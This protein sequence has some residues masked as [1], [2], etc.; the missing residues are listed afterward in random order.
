MI[1]LRIFS[2][3]IDNTVRSTG[4]ATNFDLGGG[5]RDQ[6]GKFLWHYFGYV[7]TITPL[8]WRHTHFFKLD[9][10]IISLKIQNLAKSRNFRLPVL[11]VMGHWG[12]EPQVLGDFWKFV[13]ETMHFRYNSAQIHPKK[14]WNNISPLGHALGQ[15]WVTN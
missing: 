15:K 6:N 13:T 12:R 10:F 8:K 3:Y 11:K 9:F 1:L 7:M 4:V 5:K 14:I 2:Y